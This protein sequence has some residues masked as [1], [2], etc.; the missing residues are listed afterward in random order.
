M[1]TSI[2][3]IIA[4]V[5]FAAAQKKTTFSDQQQNVSVTISSA[6]LNINRMSAW[7]SDNGQSERNPKTNNSGVAYPR[8]TS[9]AVY[10]SGILMGGYVNDGLQSGPRVTGFLY[11]PGFSVGAILGLRT[12]ETED[13]SK[14]DVR[15]YRIRNDYALADLKLDAAETNMID[16][17]AV[18]SNQIRAVRDQYKKDWLEWP[19]QKGAPFY[20]ADQDGKYSPKFEMKNG[21]EIPIL[22]PDA[23]EPGLAGAHQVIWYVANDVRT[24]QSPWKTEAIGIEVQ[25]T[26]WGYN[27]SSNHGLGNSIFKRNRII[28]KGTVSTPPSSTRKRRMHRCPKPTW[29]ALRPINRWRKYSAMPASRW[30]HRAIA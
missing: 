28:Y 9:Y 15:I 14:S 29:Q 5:V 23:D 21:K 26:I 12:G 16:S 19:A 7:Y 6:L 10:A 2:I 27:F 20:D 25:A 1:K 24:M 3:F 11:N 30:R 13:P 17:A 18:D 4:A 8:G 22:Y